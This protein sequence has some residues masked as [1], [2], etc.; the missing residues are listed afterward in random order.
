MFAVYEST[1]SKVLRV[2]EGNVS[3]MTTNEK[4][5]QFPYITL[6]L[7]CILGL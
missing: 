7:T 6:Q 3:P 5:K 1:G 2:A 4:F